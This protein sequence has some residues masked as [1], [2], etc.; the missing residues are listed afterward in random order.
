MEHSTYVVVTPV[1]DE[2]QYITRTIDA[3]MS[4]TLLPARWIVV[5]DGSTDGTGEVLD[6]CA[7]QTRWISIVHRRNRGRRAAGS[8]VMEAFYDGY[9]VLGDQPWDYLVKL[10]GDLWFFP[11][12][13]ERCLATFD[14]D[15]MLGI[16]GGTVCRLDH[17]FTKVD[18]KDPPFHV[19][20]ATKIYRRGCW[21][22]IGPLVSAPGWDTIDE[23]KA[24]F[25]GWS[26]RTFADVR[27]IQ[28][29]PTG[30]ADG[31]WRNGFKNGRANY[32]SGY[33][34]AFMAAKCLKRVVDRPVIVG[35]IALWSGF[36]SG[37]F[38]RIPRGADD[39]VVRYLRQQQVR[40]LLRRPSI[41][42]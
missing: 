6:E 27:L 40:R 19:R 33:H 12:Y 20:G 1:R 21:E 32:I 3:M 29:K 5:D 30:G 7:S 25:H 10:D 22:A 38:K 4:Q 18:S 39:R 37:Y 14:A 28:L 36:V 26:T 41:Y 23:V 34:P 42:A 2:V 11:D 15:R 8:G 16:G 31:S 13:F 9:A 17:G 24:N 35:S